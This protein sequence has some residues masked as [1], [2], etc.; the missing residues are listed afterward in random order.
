ML[1][2]YEYHKATEFNTNIPV[3]LIHGLFGSLSNL[4]M[5]ARPL[6]Q[7]SNVLQID[8][9]NHGHSAH[10]AEMDYVSMAEDILETLEYL[11]IKN[12]NVIGH[13][14]GAKIAM[15]LTET[16]AEHLNQLVLLDMAPFAYQENHHDQVFKALF[17]VQNAQVE[18]R[19]EA[20]DIMRSLLN[21]EMV[22]QFLLKSFS[23][24]Q[25]LFNVD[26]LYQ[27]YQDI[28][29]WQ[30]V[31]IWHQPTLF[32]R[33]GNSPYM[34][35]DIHLQAIERQFTQAQIETVENAGH[36]LHAEKTDE[37]NMIISRF[38]T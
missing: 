34:S 18:S 5:I 11:D 13:S 26:A 10:S 28:I 3:V 24:G 2:N 9:R 7:R 25:W 19:K 31:S 38:L 4:G 22:I 30:E 27:H 32:I 37:V 17:A 16:A 36:W 14:M 1:L 35:Q 23:K 8:V 15:K 33:G 12:F 29:G 20:T 21:E 6:I